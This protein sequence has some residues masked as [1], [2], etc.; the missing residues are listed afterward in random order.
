MALLAEDGGGGSRGKDLAGDVPGAEGFS[1]PVGDGSADVGS[2]IGTPATRD[3]RRSSSALMAA[4]IAEFSASSLSLTDCF[5]DSVVITGRVALRGGASSTGA[6]DEAVPPVSL[7][8]P[9]RPG[10]SASA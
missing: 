3:Q 5:N 6:A 9:S 8:I 10:A 7:D 4:L 1:D 2:I